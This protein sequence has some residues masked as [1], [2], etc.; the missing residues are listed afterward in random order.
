MHPA[1]GEDRGEDMHV[2]ACSRIG[3][4]SGNGDMLIIKL[5]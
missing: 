3:V 4:P 5:G 1:Q 2:V